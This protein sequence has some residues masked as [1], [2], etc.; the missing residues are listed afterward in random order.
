MTDLHA[1]EAFILAA[2][3]AT[4]VGGGAPVESCRPGSHDLAY[5]A[6]LIVIWIVIS[7]VQI[8]LV[9]RLS[10]KTIILSGQ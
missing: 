5:E 4:Y 10:M 9:K 1:L 6:G 7:V 8:L 3:A 2:K